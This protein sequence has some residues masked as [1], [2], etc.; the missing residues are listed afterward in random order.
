MLRVLATLPVFLA[1]IS[2]AACAAG[3]AGAPV[4]CSG[5]GKPVVVAAENFWGSIAGQLAGDKACVASI[6]VNPESDPHAY[7]AKPADARLIASARYVI[8]NGV[9]YDPWVP[10]LLD[11]NP[12]AG[13]VVLDIGAFLGK[14]DGDNPHLWYSPAYVESVI[15]RINADLDRINPAAAAAFDQQKAQYKAVA[16]KDYDDALQAIKTRYAGTP[17]GATE[18]IFSYLADSLGLDLVT[19]YD[20]LKAISEGSDP[21]PADKAEAENEIATRSIKVFVF[22]SQN[23]TKEVLALVD[24]ARAEKIPVTPVT[25]TLSPANLT[26]QDWQTKQLQE[27]LAALGG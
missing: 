17:V 26:F 4:P 7:E 5:S 25:E 20:Y 15:D 27:L 9:G 6:V 1:S 24:K 8:L 10:K 21:S 19:P 3:G 11:A 14:R 12:V 2:L 13:R 22:N 16:L 23:T 18:S